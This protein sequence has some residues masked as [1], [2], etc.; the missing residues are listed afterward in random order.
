MKHTYI[1]KL[2]NIPNCFLM[3]LLSPFVNHIVCPTIIA[4]N[5]VMQNPYNLK[6]HPPPSTS[7]LNDLM[8]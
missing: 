8:L 6:G 7:K 1:D 5:W 2:S 3:H 4:L